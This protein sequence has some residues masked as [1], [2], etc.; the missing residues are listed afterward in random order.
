[1]AIVEQ[2]TKEVPEAAES[3]VTNGKRPLRK[4]SPRKRAMVRRGAA[5][6]QAAPKYVFPQWAKTILVTLFWLGGMPVYVGLVSPYI[7][8]PSARSFGVGLAVSTAIFAHAFP[9]KTPPWR[10]VV[11]TAVGSA[12]TGS[13]M[14]T[15]GAGRYAL[16]TATIVGFSI[17]LLRINQGG[18]KL[19]SLTKTWRAVR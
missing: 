4:L 9:T 6:V 13:M 3:P 10:T 14:L 12:V 5:F 7:T 18:R 15:A 11:W 16:L 19:V 1:M 17:A 2:E 8:Y